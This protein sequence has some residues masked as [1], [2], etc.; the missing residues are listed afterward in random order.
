VAQVLVVLLALATPAGGGAGEL[1]VGD[2]PDGGLAAVGVDV[3]VEEVRV[4]G[5]HGL[6]V[7]LPEGVAG[8]DEG[9][10]FRVICRPW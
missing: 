9:G 4:G 10:V 1:R 7:E 6:V 2:V 8:L 5:A 3:L